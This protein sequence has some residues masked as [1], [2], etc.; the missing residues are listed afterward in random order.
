MGPWKQQPSFFHGYSFYGMMNALLLD[1]RY[2]VRTEIASIP[3]RHG[4]MRLL[5][6]YITYSSEKD[7]VDYQ[8]VVLIA[9]LLVITLVGLALILMYAEVSNYVSVRNRNIAKLLKT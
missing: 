1:L 5:F 4:H 6:F 3:K 2:L 7:D 8:I 9:I